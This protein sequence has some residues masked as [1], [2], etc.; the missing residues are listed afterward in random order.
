MKEKELIEKRN[1]LQTKMEE[2]VNT[3]KNENRTLME[4]EIQKFDEMEKE[5][6]NIDATLERKEKI[7][8]MECKKVKEYERKGIN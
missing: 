5:I 7:N 4:E 2:I 8:K 6:K 3:A 1:D